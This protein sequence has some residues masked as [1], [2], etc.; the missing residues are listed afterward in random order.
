MLSI[1]ANTLFVNRAS[2][3]MQ[4]ATTSPGILTVFKVHKCPK[5]FLRLCA[6]R[7]FSV[8]AMGP[9]LPDANNV[10]YMYVCIAY[11]IKNVALLT[12]DKQWTHLHAIYFL[13]I[14]GH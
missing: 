14:Y 11:A 8:A 10:G 5:C 7:S 12:K 1:E 6:Q 13:L 9:L 3:H 4:M 2:A